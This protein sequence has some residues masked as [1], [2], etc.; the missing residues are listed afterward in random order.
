MYAIIGWN[1]T[2]AK[3]GA[4]TE[5]KQLE[6]EFPNYVKCFDGN[7]DISIEELRSNYDRL[8]FTYQNPERYRTRNLLNPIYYD[9]D[10]QYIRKNYF[11]FYKHK[12][13]NGFSVYMENPFYSNFVPMLVPMYKPVDTPNN[14]IVLGHYTR[15]QYKPDDFAMF[16]EFLKNLD[17]DVELYVMGKC[18]YQYKPINRH[19]VY[20]YHTYDN[21][22]FWNNV[23]HYVYS[24][25][26]AYDPWPTTLQEAVNL[27]KQVIILKQNRN[28]RDGINDTEDCI[29]YHTSLNPNIYYDN[30][31][32][33]LNTW[34]YRKYYEEVFSNDFIYDIDR[35]K[36]TG[37]TDWLNSF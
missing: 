31:K 35:N 27:N 14:K 2:L 23:T 3:R 34:N 17:V 21:E 20:E 5:A 11:T 13:T 33:I 28:F 29:K 25:T 1:D 22:T 24:E 9:R 32:S 18:N 16:K 30:S 26:L 12:T 7:S 10:I 8:V 15:I 4:Y 37:F 6:I 19:I 36:N